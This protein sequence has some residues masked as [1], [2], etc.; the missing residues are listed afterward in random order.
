M[1]HMNPTTNL[2]KVQPNSI[3]DAFATLPP[4]AWTAVGQTDR[5]IGN[6]LRIRRDALALMSVIAHLIGEITAMVEISHKIPGSY[7][8]PHKNEG[9]RIDSVSRALRRLREDM[10]ASGFNALHVKRGGTEECIPTRYG[11]GDYHDVHCDIQGEVM[12]TQIMDYPVRRRNRAY[13]DLIRGVLDKRGYRMIV[14]E[15]RQ[16]QKGGNV[17]TDNVVPIAIE[18]DLGQRVTLRDVKGRMALAYE[19]LFECSQDWIRLGVPT[20]QY[21]EYK[22]KCDAELDVRCRDA[23]MRADKT[24]NSESKAL[25]E[26]MRAADAVGKR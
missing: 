26:M 14:R 5:I 23:K 11:M 2:D 12:V 8:Y 21:F 7:L 9:A 20:S 18:S 3:S 10:I 13:V 22:A 4:V 1:K 15:K 17:K 16:S 6:L 25:R 24:N 19:Q